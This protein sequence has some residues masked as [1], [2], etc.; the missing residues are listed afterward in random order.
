[1]RSSSPPRASNQNEDLD[2][3]VRNPGQDI[4]ENFQDSNIPNNAQGGAVDLEKFEDSPDEENIQNLVAN[5][6]N[7]SL[8]DI[9]ELNKEPI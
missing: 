1:M 8:N 4:F 9:H 5:S 7:K 3:V 2:N 6:Q